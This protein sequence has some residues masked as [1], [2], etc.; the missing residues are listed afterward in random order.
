MDSFAKRTAV[1]FAM[2]NSKYIAGEGYKTVEE[3][4]QTTIGF[5]ELGSPIY[6]NVFYVSWQD[7]MG[8]NSI[9]QQQ[10]NTVQTA[11]IKMSYVKEVAS[12]LLSKNI[13]IYYNCDKNQYFI[14]NSSVTNMN[15][16]ELQFQVKRVEVK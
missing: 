15:N 9:I 3:C 5:D 6:S 2:E 4:I 1:M 11:F 14:L 12:A 8:S 7:K 10:S 16:Q 13:K